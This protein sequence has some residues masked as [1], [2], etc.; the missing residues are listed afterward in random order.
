MVGIRSLD[1]LWAR[2]PGERE[3]RKRRC[4]YPLLR[5]R[6]CVSLL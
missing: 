2:G 4:T 6:V 3:A 1:S 5:G